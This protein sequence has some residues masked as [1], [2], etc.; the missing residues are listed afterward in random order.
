M[1]PFN[2][3]PPRFGVPRPAVGEDRL[4]TIHV[5]GA[6]TDAA[7][8][9][10]LRQLRGLL[11]GP[12][13]HFQV[14]SSTSSA[15]VTT[16]AAAAGRLASAPTRS[17]RSVSAS[18]LTVRMGPVENPEAVAARITGAELSWESARVLQLILSAPEGQ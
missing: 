9:A 17:S 15:T 7:R 18:F 13:T 4:L 11:G 10:V 8:D 2:F 1:N 12:V 16:E 14:A 5:H 6:D 3:V